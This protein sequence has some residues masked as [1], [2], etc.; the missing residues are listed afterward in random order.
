MENYTINYVVTLSNNSMPFSDDS[1]YDVKEVLISKDV[2][3]TEKGA[4]KYFKLKAKE[5]N[6]FKSGRG[7]SLYAN[8][9]YELYM[10]STRIA[11]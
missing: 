5:L 1:A 7:N 4:K 9:Q 8:S 3:D 10:Y 11:L 6:L 2:F